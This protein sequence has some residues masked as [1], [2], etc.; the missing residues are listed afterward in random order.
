MDVHEELLDKGGRNM[1]LL[2]GTDLL[3]VAISVPFTNKAVRYFE[4]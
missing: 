3:Y 2:M 4:V 1:E